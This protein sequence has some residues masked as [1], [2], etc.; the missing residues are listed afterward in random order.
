MISVNDEGYVYKEDIVGCYI[1][2]NYVY[3]VY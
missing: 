3:N 1:V 2:I